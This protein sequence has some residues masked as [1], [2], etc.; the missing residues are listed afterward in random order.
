MVRILIGALV[1]GV[2]LFV[3][4]FATWVFLDLHRLD[5]DPILANEAEIVKLLEGTEKG[6]YWIP[7]RDL[8]AA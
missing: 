2:V 4:Q 6:A 5:R 7:G 8:R 1:G 3:W